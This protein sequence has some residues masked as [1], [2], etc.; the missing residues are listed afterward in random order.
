MAK[1][2]LDPMAMSRICSQTPSEDFRMTDAVGLSEV[3]EKSGVRRI[4][5]PDTLYRMSERTSENKQ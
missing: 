4:Y 1:R 2:S 5:R 3:W